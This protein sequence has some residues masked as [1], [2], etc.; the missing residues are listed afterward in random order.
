MQQLVLLLPRFAIE[1][2]VGILLLMR[3]GAECLLM[4]VPLTINQADQVQQSS[5]IPV[6]HPNIIQPQL[7]PRTLA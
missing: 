2:S 5:I 4:K 1:T 7:R 3:A 6:G